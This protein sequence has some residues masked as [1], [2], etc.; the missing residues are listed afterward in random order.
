MNKKFRNTVKL[1][2]ITVLALTLIFSATPALAA[3]EYFN[4]TVFHGINGRALGLEDRDLPVNVFIN[5]ALAIPDFRF[6]EKV[7]TSLPAGDYTVSVYLLDG[8]LIESMTIPSTYI[9]G[10]VDVDIRA[11]L[12]TFGE[13]TLAVSASETFEPASTFDV[14]V[15]HKINGQRLGLPKALPVNV[16]IN[17]ALAIPDFRFGQKVETSLPAGEYTITVTL[18]DGTPLETMTVGPVDIPG[19]VQVNLNA[20]LSADLTPYIKVSVK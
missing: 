6:G 7:E 16:Y 4:L 11:Q 19:G 17:G 20:K 13:P 9:P 5:G 3:T 8:T 1:S 2:I 14:V 18:L 15:S 12:S 10:G